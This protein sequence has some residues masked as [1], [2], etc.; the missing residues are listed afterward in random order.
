[1]QCALEPPSETVG[2]PLPLIKGRHYGRVTRDAGIEVRLCAGAI[3][4]R[5]RPKL[6]C[7]CAIAPTTIQGMSIVCMRQGIMVR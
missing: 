4:N 5:Q 7:R 3:V 2:F 1:M 6:V